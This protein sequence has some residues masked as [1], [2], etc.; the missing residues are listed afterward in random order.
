VGKRSIR[1]IEFWYEM[2][3]TLNGQ[4]DVTLFGMPCNQTVG[5]NS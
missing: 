2:K 5:V 3:G 1:K 4:A